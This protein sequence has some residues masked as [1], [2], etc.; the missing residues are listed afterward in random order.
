MHRIIA[1]VA[2]ILHFLIGIFE[3][4]HS[5]VQDIEIYL[6]RGDTVVCSAVA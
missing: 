4:T 5:H 6:L 1:T 2:S 3:F